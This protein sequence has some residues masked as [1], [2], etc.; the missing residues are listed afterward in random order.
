MWPAKSMAAARTCYYCTVGAEFVE[1]FR[2]SRDPYQGLDYWKINVVQV[3]K[4][5]LAPL[6]ASA[7]E[8]QKFGEPGRGTLEKYTQK[9]RQWL[10][11]GPEA[12]YQAQGGAPWKPH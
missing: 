1:F 4:M 3:S 5:W 6:N 12:R 7:C 9:G 11:V 8:L 2:A 10:D